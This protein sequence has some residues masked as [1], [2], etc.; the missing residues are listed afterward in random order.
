MWVIL[1]VKCVKLI[2]FS[3]N[4]LFITVI[5]FQFSP[6]C[7]TNFHFSPL[8]LINCHFKI[9]HFSP[10]TLNNSKFEIYIFLGLN[11]LIT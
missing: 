1:D 8:T 7:L 10:L 6:L 11:K 9:F 4:V 3:A 2:P 5:N